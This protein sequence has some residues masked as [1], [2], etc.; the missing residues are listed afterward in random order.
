[1]LL[2]DFLPQAKVQKKRPALAGMSLKSCFARGTKRCTGER[3]QTALKPHLMRRTKESK[4]VCFK[5]AHLR[6]KVV[7]Y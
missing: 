5:L 3:A 7:D 1:M 4:I 2:S 6:G